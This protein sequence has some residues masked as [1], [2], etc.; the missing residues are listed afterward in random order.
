MLVVRRTG[1]G[2]IYYIQKLAVTNFFCDLKKVEWV[3]YI[4]SRKSREAKMQSC[5]SCQVKF[6]C[7]KNLVIFDNLLEEFKSRSKTAKIKK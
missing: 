7:P 3:F 5:F 1:C 2:K 4:D 6:H